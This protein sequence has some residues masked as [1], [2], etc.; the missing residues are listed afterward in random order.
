MSTGSDN[1]SLS[2]KDAGVD[3]DAGNALVDRI[4]GVAKSTAR[5]EVMGGLGGFGAL[6]R[7]PQ[8]YNKPVLVSGTDGVGT[9][10]RLAMD[11]KKHDT[12]GIDLVAMCVNDLVVA[13]AEPLFFLDYYAT[14]ALNV[15]TAADVVTGIGKGCELAGAALVGGETAEMPGMYEGEDYDLAG[16]CTGVVEE[17]EI[18]DGSNVKV[19]DTLIGLAS[20]GP[21]SNGYSL[22][23]KIIE[24]R[25]ADLN[26]TIDGKPLADALMEPTRIY[27]KS[28]LKLIKESQV[29]ALSHITGGGLLENIPRVLPASAKAVIDLNSWELPAVFQW[30]QT[31]GNVETT[32]MYR[33]FN[34]G[35]GM[36]ICVPAEEANNAL[37]VLKAAGEDAWVIGSIEN[38]ADGE[39]QVELRG[40][41][42]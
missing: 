27:V 25:G 8:G 38:A 22:I 1:T 4:K 9:K 42:A 7:I 16:F 30:L 24:V 31:Q 17:D 39:E 13:G 2:Y 41:E 14:G 21:H 36:V 23:R 15:D 32:E 29:N 28:L 11:L 19:G 40:A 10:L 18:I 34:C 6:C 35:V 3:I 5:P 33:T 26:E 37:N 20:S 12:I